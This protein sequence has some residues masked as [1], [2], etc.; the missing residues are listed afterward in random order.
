[1]THNRIDHVPPKPTA[2]IRVGYV[3][4]R[5]TAWTIKLHDEIMS[6]ISEFNTYCW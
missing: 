3:P 4:L 6:L 2:D 1:M 5:Q